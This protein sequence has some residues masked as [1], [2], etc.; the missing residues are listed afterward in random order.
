MH[1]GVSDVHAMSERLTRRVAGEGTARLHKGACVIWIANGLQRIVCVPGTDREVIF[2]RLRTLRHVDVARKLIDD[3]LALIRA[4]LSST[5][6][7]TAP[8]LPF[9]SA[10]FAGVL[11][12]KVVRL[13]TCPA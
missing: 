7:F 5:A 6:D 8:K 3:V 11:G 1:A 13:L 10:A 2:H 12:V 4:A 9:T